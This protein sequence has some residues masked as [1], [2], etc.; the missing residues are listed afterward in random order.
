ML[1]FE[2][3]KNETENV[4]S[5]YFNVTNIEILD[6]NSIPYGDYVLYR[7]RIYITKDT[8]F[9]IDYENDL[10][11]VALEFRPDP[12]I[13]I[14]AKQQ[15]LTVALNEVMNQTDQYFSSVTVVLDQYFK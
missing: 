11:R 14:S 7:I 1:T 15:Q 12:Q 10:W 3:A 8:Y 9:T 2:Q 5:K 13:M 6:D 4:F